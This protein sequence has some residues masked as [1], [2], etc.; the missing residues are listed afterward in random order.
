MPAGEGAFA[1][2]L[3]RALVWKH[4]WRILGRVLFNTAILW[5][6]VPAHPPQARVHHTH[7]SQTQALPVPPHQA[8]SHQAL[9]HPVPLHQVLP[10]PA[11]QPAVFC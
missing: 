5:P 10:H 3:W 1:A 9:L 2:P 7:F 4:L 6:A 11:P 8:V